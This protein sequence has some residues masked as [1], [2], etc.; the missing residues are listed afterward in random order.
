MTISSPRGL[1]IF[2]LSSNRI[3]DKGAATLG[4]SSQNLFRNFVPTQVV[5][6]EISCTW[7]HSLQLVSFSVKEV[8]IG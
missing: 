6:Y 7:P 1:H 5:H 4:N 8:F 3:E 2:L